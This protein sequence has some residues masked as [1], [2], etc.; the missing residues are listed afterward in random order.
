MHTARLKS[1]EALL[2]LTDEQ[3]HALHK[4]E[5]ALNDNSP[6]TFLFMVSPAVGKTL[7]YIHAIKHTIAQQ[8]NAL[9]LVPEIALTPQLIDRFRA[10][11]DDNIAVLHSKMSVGQRFDQWRKILRQRSKYHHR[12][13]L[14]PFCTHQQS[15]HHHLWTEEKTPNSYKQQDPAPRYQ[16]RDC[17]II[18]ASMERAV[19]ILGSATPSMESYFNA[20]KWKIPSTRMEMHGQCTAPQSTYSQ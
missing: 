19:T 8:K 20:P 18:R 10:A 9:I 13:T 11:F 16:A 15:G 14:C 1:N 7:V 12:S 3:N 5:Q 4:I 17:A 6:K 2:E